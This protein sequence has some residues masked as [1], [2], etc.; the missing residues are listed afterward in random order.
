MKKKIKLKVDRPPYDMGLRLGFNNDPA[1]G[2]VGF[3][4]ATGFRG[5][6]PFPLE[7]N[8]KRTQIRN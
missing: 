3:F 2:A 5:I 8:W 7:A 4:D 6:E 1:K